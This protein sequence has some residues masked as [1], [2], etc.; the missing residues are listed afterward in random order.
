MALVAVPFWDLNFWVSE[1][2]G[3]V[4]SAYPYDEDDEPI[5]NH[6]CWVRIPLTSYEIS[7]LRLGHVGNKYSSDDDF[8]IG[9]EYFLNDYHNQCDTVRAKLESLP[10]FVHP[11]VS[12]CIYVI[13]REVTNV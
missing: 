5:G 12:G 6:M 10:E 7:K 2:D 11:D 3:W 1:D 9:L 13:N 8:W 4:I